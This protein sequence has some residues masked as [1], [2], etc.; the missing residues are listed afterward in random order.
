MLISGGQLDLP[1]DLPDGLFHRAAQIA[2]AHAVLDGDVALV[3]FAIDFGRAVVALDV[4]ELRQ[5]DAFAAGASRRIFSIASLVSR[6][7][8]QIAHHQVV[9]LFAL[10]H[11][12]QRIAAHGGLDGILHVGGVDLVA[13]RRRRGPP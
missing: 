3:S 4:A 9:A 10:Q 7:C 5:G 13:R 2:P 8:G 12:G 6:Y 1:A 11:L